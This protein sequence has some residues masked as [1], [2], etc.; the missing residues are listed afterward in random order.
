MII[1]RR[2]TTLP[3]RFAP[4]ACALLFPMLAHSATGGRE[5][6]VI[7]VGNVAGSQ[8]TQREGNRV[9]VHFEFNDRGRGPVTDTLYTLDEKG[10]P[11]SMVV[12]GVDYMKAPV[13]E[14]FEYDGR[15]ASWKS[16]VDEGSSSTRGFYSS[17]DGPAAEIVLLVNALQA[18]GGQLDLL[19]T[20]TVRLELVEEYSLNEERTLLHYELIGLGFEP[21]PIWMNPDGSLFAVVDGWFSLVEKGAEEH[22]EA[23][24]E[25]Q[26]VRRYARYI[27][28][29]DSLRQ[30]P[31]GPVLIDNARI[32]DVASGKILGANAAMIDGG[33]ITGLLE[34]GQ[35]RPDG[36]QVIDAGGRTL[37]PGLW[38]MHTHLDL[39]SGPLNIA[40]G[41][42]TV[43]DLANDHDKLLS[44]IEQFDSGK[45]IGPHVY[46]A[47][48]IDGAGPYAGPSKALIEDQAGAEKW[49]DFYADNGYRH[50]KL[51]SSIPVDLVPMMTRRAHDRGMRVSGHI[52]AGMWAEDAIRQGFDEVQHINMV[53]LNFY[54]DVTET[55]NPDRFIKVA[56]RAADMDLQSG[57]F[58][59]F[60]TLLREHHTVVD[61]TVAVFFDMFTHRPG[62]PA[63]SMRTAYEHLPAQVARGALKGGLPIPDGQRERYAASAQR[64]LDAIR[65]LHEAG[66]PIVAGTDGMPGFTL[67][68]ELEFYAQAG[69]PPAE[70]LRIATLG[71][72]RVLGVDD[73]VG[74]VAPGYR[75]DLILVD[76]QPDQHIEDIR[77]VSWVMKDGVMYDT[78]PIYR[79]MGV[80]P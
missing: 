1:L 51:Y 35:A 38:D 45:A 77:H 41:V 39:S 3:R 9:Q 78:A 19:P 8:L 18:A 75:A 48:F 32:L 23:L 49:I 25:R 80:T 20:G 76:G 22:T 33:T 2:S 15:T 69:I 36:L 73:K 12:T 17:I 24:F 10:L 27:Q 40:A 14:T 44:I 13:K 62:Q 46:K 79:S 64:L 53:F 6:T 31:A 4:L 63:A 74:L 26:K 34:P 28:V 60:I 50:I 42:T 67:Q 58:Q 65:V 61:P 56:E 68:A 52:P 57:Q 7:L 16:A 71:A 43:R 72:A 5:H 29:A 30:V 11:V 55:R 70:V 66:V 47:G 21:S 37:M 59:D 54:K